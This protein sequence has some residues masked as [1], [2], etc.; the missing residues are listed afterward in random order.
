MA[1]LVLPLM[2]LP[3]RST[4][5]SRWEPLRIGFASLLPIGRVP[6][7]ELLPWARRTG[8]VVKFRLRKSPAIGRSSALRVKNALPEEKNYH[9][10]RWHRASKARLESRLHVLLLASGAGW[11]PGLEAYCRSPAAAERSDRF[12]REPSAEM[13]RA[14]QTARAACTRAVG[15]EG[16]RAARC[17]SRGR[18][19]PE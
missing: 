7:T 3:P 1:G 12:C 17:V 4:L 13:Q 2:T 9:F 18:F 15:R 8:C 5:A 19:R 14:V 11:M 16:N 10:C 6:Q